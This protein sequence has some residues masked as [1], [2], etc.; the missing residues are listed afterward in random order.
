MKTCPRPDLCGYQPLHRFNC[1]NDKESAA[2][3]GIS[4]VNCIAGAVNYPSCPSPGI[5]G[6]AELPCVGC[7]LAAL[8][9]F[10]GCPAPNQCG[11]IATPPCV[12]CV[13]GRATAGCK[14]P[15][16]CAYYEC[17]DCMQGMAMP[18]CLNPSL[19]P[20]SAF[21]QCTM[22]SVFQFNSKVCIL[23]QAWQVSN[24]AQW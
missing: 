10:R 7:N 22:A 8:N 4:C 5:C 1:S 16:A 3:Q 15:T 11:G 17:V 14:D 20:S 6:A 23:F 2:C 19:C 24:A 18:R 12:G 21:T 13:A 9:S